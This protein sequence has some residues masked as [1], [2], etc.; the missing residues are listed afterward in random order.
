MPP[1]LSPFDV[2][3]HAG[4]RRVVGDGGDPAQVVGERGAAVDVPGDEPHH[5]PLPPARALGHREGLDDPGP[6]AGRLQGDAPVA[7]V[8]EQRGGD[9]APGDLTWRIDRQHLTHP[10]PA[11]PARAVAAAEPRA[12][13]RRGRPA[14]PADLEALVTLTPRSW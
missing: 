5:D 2:H 3:S 6:G 7:A 1:K 9:G 4:G 11:Q 12:G 8:H 13:Y 10:A 14:E